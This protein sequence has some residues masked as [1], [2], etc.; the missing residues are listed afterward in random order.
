MSIKEIVTLILRKRRESMYFWSSLRSLKLGFMRGLLETMK[1]EG[2]RRSGRG[3]I[4]DHNTKH[5]T[6]SPEIIRE[7]RAI[8]LS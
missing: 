1:R 4:Y 7:N 2:W 5:V 6:A 8:H 3:L